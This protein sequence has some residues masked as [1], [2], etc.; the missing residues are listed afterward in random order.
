MPDVW[1]YRRE[2]LKCSENLRIDPPDKI[3]DYTHIHIYDEAGNPM[4]IQG[5][6]VSLRDPKGHV[7]YNHQLGGRQNE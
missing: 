3:T 5:D 1:G 6:P 2:P 4:D 7:P